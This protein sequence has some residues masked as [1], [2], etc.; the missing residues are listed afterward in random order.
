MAAGGVSG[1]GEEEWL[2]FLFRGKGKYFI[3]SNSAAAASVVGHGLRRATGRSD[4]CSKA[5]S[6]ATRIC[7]SSKTNNQK[8]RNE[9]P[10]VLIEG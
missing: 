7:L 2:S 8:I 10:S 4:A 1:E 9:L 5:P 3:V 6:T